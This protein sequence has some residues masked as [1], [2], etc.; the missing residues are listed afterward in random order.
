[1][2]SVHLGERLTQLRTTLAAEALRPASYTRASVAH[3]AGV[4]ADAL[5]R[6]E[7]E[8][9]GTATTLA[10]VLRHYQHKGVN[11]AWVLEPDNTEIPLYGFRD[12]FQDDPLPRARKPLAALHR[13]LHP[14][15]TELDA[16]QQLTPHATHALLT[17]VGH[18]I[19]HA[20]QHLLPRRGLLH[21]KAD[22]RTYQRVLP[23]VPAQSAGWR[24]AA[25][26]AVPAHYYE[27]GESLPRCGDVASYLA[28]D[29]G[30]KKVANRDKC[31]A[32]Q[33]QL[34]R[35]PS[36]SLPL[37]VPA[38]APRQPAVPTG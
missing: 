36:P 19:R 33:H 11:L 15:L 10:A 1:M 8:G 3:A 25:L 2:S 5:A 30:G 14:V 31:G 21:G 7:K 9:G 34:S 6:L 18:G 35:S 13:L 26:F 4:S 17:Q 27:A 12:I 16:G 23:P 29:P 32:C 24:P 37:D 38:D 20:L 28:H 22:W